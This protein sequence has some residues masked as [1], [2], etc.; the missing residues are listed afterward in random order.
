MLVP[1][2][3][4]TEQGARHAMSLRRHIADRSPTLDDLAAVAADATGAVTAL[5]TIADRTTQHIVGAFN[6]PVKTF[7][8]TPARYDQLGEFFELTHLDER[9]AFADHPLQIRT[10]VTN[11][12]ALITGLFHQGVLIGGLSV[13]STQPEGAFTPDHRAVLFRIAR[14]AEAVIRS[15]VALSRMATEALAVLT[16]EV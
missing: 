13:S 5:I 11:R 8:R 3:P 10:D 12:S 7:P 2:G 15:E 1:N 16:G 6:C 14:I 9:P 4:E